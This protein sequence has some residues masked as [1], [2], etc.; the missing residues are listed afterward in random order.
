MLA[1]LGSLF[2]GEARHAQEVPVAQN[3]LFWIC[4]LEP[5]GFPESTGFV[6]KVLPNV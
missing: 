1:T 6:E 5:N 3:Y 2:R 4:K